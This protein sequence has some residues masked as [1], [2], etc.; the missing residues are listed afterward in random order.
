MRRNGEIFIN[1]SSIGI[2]PFLVLE[3][4]RAIRHLPVFRLRIRIQGS[5][6]KCRSPCVLI[7]NNGYRLTV[8]A[9]G[10]RDRLDRGELCRYV[11]SSLITVLARLSLHSRPLRSAA[12]PTHVQGRSADISSHR[13]RLLV[14][15][16][17]EV[18]TTGPG[19]GHCAYSF[20]LARTHQDPHASP[21]SLGSAFGSPSPSIR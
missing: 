5:V 2:Y 19:Q 21:H 1:N 11:Q 16:D 3:R 12:R 6:E 10:R 17:G 13:S 18:K 9:F 8:P 15:F 7:G 14:A 20:R 4:E